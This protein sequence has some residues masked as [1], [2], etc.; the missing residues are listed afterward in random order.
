VKAVNNHSNFFITQLQSSISSTVSMKS[1]NCT[2]K[3]ISVRGVGAFP[4]HYHG[5]ERLWTDPAFYPMATGESLSPGIRA[6]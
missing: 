2:L 6:A 3:K 5:S 1:R 4:V